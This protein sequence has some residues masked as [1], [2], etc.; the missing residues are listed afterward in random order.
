MVFEKRPAPEGPKAEPPVGGQRSRLLRIGSVTLLLTVGVGAA[1][2]ARAQ[3][4]TPAHR[5]LI[6]AEDETCKA[7]YTL[8]FSP[9]ITPTPTT[10][11]VT[12]AGTFQNCASPDGSAGTAHPVSFTVGTGTS[13]LGC[14][15]TFPLTR[16]NKVTWSD[17]TTSTVDVH[18]TV[19]IDSTKPMGTQITDDSDGT[20]VTAGRDV[21]DSVSLS[22]TVQS[23]TGACTNASPVTA[24][25][26]VIGGEAHALL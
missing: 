12:G 24:M 8:H 18:D 4:H 17:G 5:V 25:T 9:G 16:T 1:W 10:Q 6:G 7:T 20:Q 14:S 22:Q 2:Q 19:A 3:S 21:D 23:L 15:G 26:G 13:V 11:T